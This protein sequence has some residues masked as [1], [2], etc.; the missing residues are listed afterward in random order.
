MNSSKNIKISY[1][2]YG[3]K[4]FEDEMIIKYMTVLSKSNFTQDELKVYEKKMRKIFRRFFSDITP[5]ISRDIRKHQ[6]MLKKF[7][8]KK[9]HA[10]DV[11]LAIVGSGEHLKM[12]FKH[13]YLAVAA[14]A[15]SVDIT[16]HVK[17]NALDFR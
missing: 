17:G 5:I 16:F 15:K 12:L 14:G 1:F 11:L 3:I 4:T 7:E 9:K 13:L 6:S 2:D 8:Q 10:H